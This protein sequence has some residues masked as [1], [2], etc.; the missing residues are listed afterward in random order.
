MQKF[1]KKFTSFSKKVF[2]CNKCKRLV[3]FRDKIILK[4]RKSYLN[5]IY[6]GKPVSGFGDLNGKIIIIGLAPAAHGATRT[7]RVFTGD[8]SADFLFNCLFKSGLSNQSNSKHLND[9]LKLN[10][11][12]ITLALRCVPPEDKPTKEEL[13]NCS[14]FFREELNMI[15]NKKVIVALGKIA[16]DTCIKFFKENYGLLGS[17]KFAHGIKYNINGLTIF[18]CYHPS[19]RNVNTKRINTTK[20]THLLKKAKKLI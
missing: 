15:K 7:G 16:F 20:M 13:K 2:K 6:W 10:N 3:K 8:K 19:P 14:E 9:G 5:Q 12:F 11:T 18:G 1:N 17:Y 4:K